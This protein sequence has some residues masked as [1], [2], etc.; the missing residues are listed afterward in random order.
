M[1]ALAMPLPTLRRLWDRLSIYLPVLLMGALALGS[2]WLLR[3]TPMPPEPPPER[4]PSHEPDYYMREFAVKTF[5]VRGELQNEL[6]GAEIRHYPDTD[7]LEVDEAR[8]RSFNA[9]GELTTAR[10]RRVT[11]NADQTVYDLTG[12]AVVVRESVP[13]VEFRGEQLRILVQQDRIESSQPVL[14]IRGND[15][16]T[17]D[18]LQYDDASRQANLQGRVRATLAPR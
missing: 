4:A 7:T 8:I 11:T 5:D 12:E 14:L 6:R 2:Y 18:R 3:A 16:I 9:S 13:R 1:S 15:R 17:A 10:A